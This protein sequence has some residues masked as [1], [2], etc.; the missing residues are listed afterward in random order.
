MEKVKVT[1]PD[2]S[3]KEYEA[4]TTVEDVAYSI[5][6]GLGRDAIAGVVDGKEVDASYSI[7]ED[8]ELSIITI[9]SEDAL[10]IIRH[11][12]SHVMAQAVKRL[13]D[14]VQVAIGPT[15]EDGFYYDFD[16]EESFNQES[17]TEIEAEMEKIIK[18]DIEIERKELPRAEAIKLMEERNEEYKLELIEELDDEMISL[19][20]Q[21]DY[22]DL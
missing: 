11:T 22:V 20:F 19:Y 1:L 17:L 8:V 13:Y 14:N 4:G 9:D 15:I 16:L 18:E 2:G 10:D 5:G 12:T 6:S 21:G 3:V 7:E